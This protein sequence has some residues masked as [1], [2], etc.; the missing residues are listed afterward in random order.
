M[1]ALRFKSSLLKII[2]SVG[3][4][5]VS[6]TVIIVLRVISAEAQIERIV[7]T[8]SVIVATLIIG[9]FIIFRIIIITLRKKSQTA[10][11]YQVE[12]LDCL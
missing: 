10:G 1:F 11:E 2:I 6:G 8:V 5:V 4:F 3:T 12:S 9:R 7:N